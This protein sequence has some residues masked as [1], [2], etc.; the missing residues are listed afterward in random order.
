MVAHDVLTYLSA[1][2]VNF[3][4]TMVRIT[5]YNYSDVDTIP[6]NPDYRLEY[7]EGKRPTVT[8]EDPMYDENPFYNDFVKY[9][10]PV[11]NTVSSLEVLSLYSVEPDWGMDFGLKLSPIQKFMGGSNGYRH[12]RYVLFYFIRAGLLKEQIKYFDRLS[13]IAFNKKDTYWGLR[14]SARAIH[15][16]EDYLTPVHAKPSSEIFIVKNILSPKK[17]FNISFNY[18]MNFE[19]LTGY[20]IWHGNEMLIKA[21]KKSELKNYDSLNKILMFTHMKVRRLFYPIFKELNKLWKKEMLNKLLIITNKDA[22]DTKKY[23]K[24]LEYSSE[25][26]EYSSSIVKGYI[27]NFIIPR[28]KECEYEG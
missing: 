16:L 18:H 14:F 6:Y 26:L 7:R 5:E 24:V 11:N 8:T 10:K 12:M 22:R 4:D 1:K 28:F 23:K 2:A 19:K 17:I 21:I 9:S 27:K 25:W 20:H 3:P 15:Y 13:K